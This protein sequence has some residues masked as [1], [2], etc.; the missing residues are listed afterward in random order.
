MDQKN[1]KRKIEVSYYIE[2]EY[3]K[4]ARKIYGKTPS[5]IAFYEQ[6]LGIPFPWAKY[7][8]ISGRDYVSGAMENTTCTLHGEWGNIIMLG[9]HHNLV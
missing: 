3:E 1:E 8:Q 7:A 6:K 9:Y 5:M 2:K 4:E